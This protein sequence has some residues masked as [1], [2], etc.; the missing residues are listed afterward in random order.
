MA[1][2]FPSLTRIIVPVSASAAYDGHAGDR[3]AGVS[4]ARFH[5]LVHLRPDGLNGGR[6]VVRDG[7]DRLQGPHA[8][9]AVVDGPCREPCIREAGRAGIDFVRHHVGEQRQLEAPTP[10]VRSTV[11][12]RVI[13]E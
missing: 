9:G 2:S 1:F 11:E 7:D 13:Q 10:L 5:Q 6:S 3:E 4:S 12:L 8:C